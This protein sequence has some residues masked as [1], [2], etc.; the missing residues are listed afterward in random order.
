VVQPNAVNVDSTGKK[1]S[2]VNGG[3]QWGWTR[4]VDELYIRDCYTETIRTLDKADMA[5]IGG[6]P[7]IGKSVFIF[8]FIYVIVSRAKENKEK[9]PTFLI[10]DCDGIGYFLRVDD[11]GY[12]IVYEPKTTE[13]PD[14]LIT[15]TI[16]RSNPSFTKLYLHVSSINNVNVKD[17]YKLMLNRQPKANKTRPQIYLP[18]FT[19]EEYF[20]ID[21]GKVDQVSRMSVV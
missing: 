12:G 18:G 1:L 16:G 4:D 6:T 5:M 21:G 7:G 10:R 2:F 8:Y 14:Y 3:A 9:I 19:L 11:N 13:T 20:E 15:D 17:L